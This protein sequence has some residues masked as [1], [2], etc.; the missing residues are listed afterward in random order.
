MLAPVLSPERRVVDDLA[1]GLTPPSGAR[2]NC[3]L[4]MVTGRAGVMARALQHGEEYGRLPPSIAEVPMGILFMA[5]RTALPVSLFSSVVLAVGAMGG[6]S[7]GCSRD[8]LAEPRA[9]GGV[10]VASATVAHPRVG[11]VDACAAG[12]ATDCRKLGVAHERGASD[13][14][15]GRAEAAR[16]Y[17]RACELGD[18]YGC[19][20]LHC[21]ALDVLAVPRG[22]VDR[23]G[24]S[25]GSGL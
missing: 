2:R 12:D 3:P 10:A 22:G 7:A 13:G 6:T 1:N 23:R 5:E 15:T 8:L 25:C 17:R 24:P 4:P 19:E 18:A 9:T 16:Y 11:A 20:A 21:L 14:R